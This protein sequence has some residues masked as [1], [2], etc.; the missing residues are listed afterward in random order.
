[1]FLSTKRS[2]SLS[3]PDFSRTGFLK[4]ELFIFMCLLFVA[5]LHAQTVLITGKITDPGAAAISG[6]TIALSD[7]TRVTTTSDA[8]GQF[9]LQ[10]DFATSVLAPAAGVS[11]M[12]ILN[13]NLTLKITEGSARVKISQHDISGKLL[14]RI[15]DQT[16][17]AGTHTLSLPE[18]A[19]VMARGIVF[20]RIAINGTSHTVRWNKFTRV[21]I[22]GQKSGMPSQAQSAAAVQLQSVTIHCD[23]YYDQELP[24][25]SY[26]QD[27]GALVFQR[28]SAEFEYIVRTNKVGYV[29]QDSQ[30]TINAVLSDIVIVM[31]GGSTGP[32]G[33]IPL[34]ANEMYDQDFKLIQIVGDRDCKIEAWV[35]IW[36][37]ADGNNILIPCN[38]KDVGYGIMVINGSNSSVNPDYL[39]DGKIATVNGLVKGL[40]KIRL[41]DSALP[42][43][44]MEYPLKVGGVGLTLAGM[45]FDDPVL[46]V[47]VTNGNPDIPIY[48]FEQGFGDGD[49]FGYMVMMKGDEVTRTA[50]ENGSD[51]RSEFSTITVN[52]DS[53]LIY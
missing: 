38:A 42:I 14:R 45:M 44:D 13:N 31:L 11:F 4:M 2:M 43:N 20:L 40:P 6:C 41:R 27:L 17:S 16:F 5:G 34:G 51:L 39:S 10:T 32:D 26:T 19:N 30:I 46:N 7:S 36:T 9:K 49:S 18:P 24:L 33:S 12:T 15:F 1:M 23:G 21:A 50:G 25:N 8:Q 22:A 52:F 37:E 3:G 35:K 53:W 28:S 48:G 47:K 29:T